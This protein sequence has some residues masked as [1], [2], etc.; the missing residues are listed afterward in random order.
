M[1]RAKQGKLFQHLKSY[2]NHRFAW[3][4]E[5]TFTTKEMR[6]AIGKF[7]NLTSWKRYNKN[8]NYVLHS[9]LGHLR[10]L[11]CI[12]RIAHGVYSINSPIP[13]WFGSF[14]FA[15]LKGKLNHPNNL[16][17]NGLP[18]TQKVNPWADV[19]LERESVKFEEKVALEKQTRKQYPANVEDS[20]EFRIAAMSSLLEEQTVKLQE[21]KNALIELQALADE[22]NQVELVY[23]EELITRKYNVSY[24]GKDY[25]VINTT[26]SDD[27]FYQ[28]RWVVEEFDC[29]DDIAQYLINWVKENCK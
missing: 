17:W 28:D 14:H 24:L 3:G 2:I 27:V 15:G 7:E 26:D 19:L 4:N 18:S 12:A 25:T 23:Q 6:S 21:I 16:Y 10:E 11:G 5:G 20:I 22:Q 13:T 9:Y 1:P 29:D 8:P